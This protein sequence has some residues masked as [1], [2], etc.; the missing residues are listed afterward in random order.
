MKQS[1]NSGPAAPIAMPISDVPVAPVAVSF[2][3]EPPAPAKP[4]APRRNA[5]RLSRGRQVAGW[6][7]DLALL[8]G[9]GVLHVS[10]AAAGS[11]RPPWEILLAAPGQWAALFG[12]LAVALSWLTVSLFGR[13]PG[14][15]L[16]GQR[17]RRVRGGMPDALTAF[18]RAVLSA[19]SAGLGGFGFALA[20]FDA[21]G[22]TL[23]DRLC[24]CICVV[25]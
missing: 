14:M 1:F 20:L 21:R 9:L 19:V 8:A 16:T 24:G 11:G 25:D 4:V 7:G 2:I 12:A 3:S 13:T 22:R 15:A 5:A 23:H 10:L 17:L 18:C 6:A